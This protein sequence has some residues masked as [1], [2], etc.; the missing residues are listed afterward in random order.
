MASVR[1]A[2]VRRAGVKNQVFEQIRDR[3][4]ERGWLPG[5]KIPSENALAE[6]L[7]VSRAPIREALQML[8][9]LG[10]LETRHGGGTYVREYSGELFLNPLLPM[11]ALDAPDILHVLEYRKIVERGIVSLAVERACAEEIDEAE[12]AFRAM[13]AHKNDARAF[14][15]ADLNFHLALAKATGNPVVMKV[16][17]VITDILK[18]SMY[19]I[20][21]SLGARDGLYY[22]RRILDAIK[23]G[24]GRG[25]ESLMEE[26]VERTIQ[27]LKSK[28][29][30]KEDD[31][32]AGRPRLAASPAAGA[33][34][35]VSPKSKNGAGRKTRAGS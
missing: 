9:S 4:V 34:K 1:L 6:A 30:K 16:T 10:L 18:T 27:R 2:P 28:T 32:G 23:A 8:A 12:A 3:I 19:G 14:A 22:H 25:A 26:H 20:V 17:A 5:A 21:D 33:R 31:A 11:L 7:G 24:D 13:Q 15:Q 29:R 35:A